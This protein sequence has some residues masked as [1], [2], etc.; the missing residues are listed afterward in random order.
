MSPDH[1]LVDDGW[2]VAF[3]KLL[4][5]LAA[6]EAQRLSPASSGREA[7]YRLRALYNW[8][9]CMHY[10]GLLRDRLRGCGVD[11]MWTHLQSPEFE[12]FTP[13]C[14]ENAA[15]STHST[16]QAHFADVSSSSF[17]H[18]G[19]GYAACPVT[20]MLAKCWPQKRSATE[21]FSD[22]DGLVSKFVHPLVSF[23][24]WISLAIFCG[25]RTSSPDAAWLP[26]DHPLMRLAATL[27]VRKRSIWRDD[28]ARHV[29]EVAQFPRG[30]LWCSVAPFV[31]HSIV[32]IMDGCLAEGRW[33]LDNSPEAWKRVRLHADRAE[34]GGWASWATADGTQPPCQRPSLLMEALYQTTRA[35]SLC[36]RIP[37][38]AY[39]QVEGA[40]RQSLQQAYADVPV[41]SSTYDLTAQE[42]AAYIPP[43]S[44]LPLE[45]YSDDG[46]GVERGLPVLGSDALEAVRIKR[47][48]VSMFHAVRTC[49]PYNTAAAAAPLGTP[50][51][52]SSFFVAAAASSSSSAADEGGGGAW[53]H[54]DDI[55]LEQTERVVSACVDPIVAEIVRMSPDVA[56]RASSSSS[57]QQQQ[58]R[59][60]ADPR[61]G[62]GSASSKRVVISSG[63]VQSILCNSAIF[64]TFLTLV[65][66]AWHEI[67]DCRA[68]P[69]PAGNADDNRKRLD[70]VAMQTG[71]PPAVVAR[72]Y[73]FVYCPS[74]GN[75][76]STAQRFHGKGHAKTVR[77]N[78][79]TVSGISNAVFDARSG[80]VHCNRRNSKLAG[81]CARECLRSISLLDHALVYRGWMYTLCSE[82]DCGTQMEVNPLQHVVS[83]DGYLCTRCTAGTIRE[84]MAAYSAKKRDEADKRRKELDARRKL[85]IQQ[86]KDQRK[87][88][89]QQKKEQHN[90][91]MQQKKE[92]TQLLRQI[93]AGF[94]REVGGRMRRKRSGKYE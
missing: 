59:S 25:Y 91:E 60:A 9:A 94:R 35:N 37:R 15:F 50:P 73:D 87:A 17:L 56:L 21:R 90:Q 5:S 38:S 13:P 82:P 68:I 48:L 26:V 30:R 11:F 14:A 36:P 49:L 79:D 63:M 22:I 47:M 40:L 43:C 83:N 24:E 55:T 76:C 86:R 44:V 84:R 33:M 27:W 39:L 28:L 80:R 31:S 75:I 71:L 29:S 74:C 72:R 93:V 6:D 70:L 32:R 78:V 16:V 92:R 52:S 41:P 23:C 77:Y 57:Q 1:R 20:R 65:A 45:P 62:G 58:Q 18:V 7:L 89:A 34:E 8:A 12:G 85:D 88:D 42:I 67:R 10:S 64:L 69:L 4:F 53:V 61:G 46:G 54:R 19:K 3:S 66:R 2:F 81:Q 51:L